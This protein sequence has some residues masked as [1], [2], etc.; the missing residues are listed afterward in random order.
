MPKSRAALA[1]SLAMLALIAVGAHAPY[2]LHG[3]KSILGKQ[4][5]VVATD[6]LELS[7]RG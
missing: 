4:V 7:L 3:F 1:A 5:S 6:A 2:P